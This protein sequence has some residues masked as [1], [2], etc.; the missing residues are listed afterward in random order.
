ML[1]VLLSPA[2][3]ASFTVLWSLSDLPSFETA[4]SSLWTSTTIAEGSTWS[5]SLDVYDKL[6]LIAFFASLVWEDCD[7]EEE[8]QTDPE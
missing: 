4:A 8:R 3:M 7:L 6:L 2:I 1:N 5:S